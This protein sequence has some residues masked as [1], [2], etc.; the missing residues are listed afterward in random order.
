MSKTADVEDGEPDLGTDRDED[1]IADILTH[2]DPIRSLTEHLTAIVDETKVRLDDDGLHVSHVDPANVCMLDVTAPAAGFERFEVT[3][4][5]SIGLNLD[6]FETAIQWA[7][8]G[9]GDGD[10]D[11]VTIEVYDD[12]TRIRVSVTRPDRGM[13]RFS[14]WFGL[15]PETLR[16]EPNIPELDLRN[17]ADPSPKG[18]KAGVQSLDE[19]HRYALVTREAESFVLSSQEGYETDLDPDDD[20]GVADTVYYGDTAWSASDGTGE[21]DVS[22]FSL[23]YLKDVTKALDS[24]KADRVTVCWGNEFPVQFRFE[25]EDWGHEG[26]WMLAPRIQKE[27][28]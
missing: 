14:E 27:E 5:T 17:R 19:N 13:K 22:L 25:N 4:E 9:R 8:K 2:G 23:D 10:G 7:R 16:E 6:T 24:S 28:S 18:L 26:V 12:P 15:D 1:P 21:S 20:V 3:E 11:P